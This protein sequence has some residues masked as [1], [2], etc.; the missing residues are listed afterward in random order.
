MG[1][2]T[3]YCHTHVDSGRRYVGLT[4]KTMMQRWNQHVY[5]SKVRKIKL[6][7]YWYNAIRKYGKDAFSH[8]VLEVC[9]T[10][11]EANVAEI[12]WI[13]FHNSTN[14]NRGFNLA[15]G[16]NHPPKDLGAYKTKM[17]IA[18]RASLQDP[19]VRIRRVEATK[20]MWQ[21]PEYRNKVSAASKQV[22]SD[23]D[24]KIM[25]SKISQEITSRPEVKEKIGNAARGRIVSE[26]TRKIISAN[27]TGR[28]HS[29]EVIAKINASNKLAV[30]DESRKKSSL[31][32]KAAW[33][34]PELRAK[35]MVNI[36]ANASNPEIREKIRSKSLGRKHS[37]ETL[38]KIHEHY[39][40]AREQ[41]LLDN[42]THYSCKYHGS[43]LIKECYVYIRDGYT[44]VH[45][46]QCKTES[47][48]ERRR[49]NQNRTNQ[50]W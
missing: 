3:I 14:K 22:W 36:R 37:K 38:E 30:T 15:K 47:Q 32:A 19:A 17:S 40:K 5:S 28:R 46:K 45:C 31:T 42:A 27:M 18:V 35:M 9:D 13:E 6:P 43:V 24:Y 50:R 1:H 44:K 48:R 20:K 34:D 25:M 49:N 21:D 11:E 29:P 41:R 39:R 4:K 12:K 23:P 8:E 7:N 26:E 2:W 16:G 33:A 10:L